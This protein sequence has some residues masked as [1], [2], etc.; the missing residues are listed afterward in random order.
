MWGWPRGRASSFLWSSS[1]AS[2]TR[3]ARWLA[4]WGNGGDG[5][6]GQRCC[7][8]TSAAGLWVAARLAPTT[9][10]GAAADVAWVL[11]LLAAT[12][13][14]RSWPG[15]PAAAPQRQH[16][17]DLQQQVTA[18]HKERQELLRRVN[19]LKV[20]ACLAA[21]CGGVKRWRVAMEGGAG[22]TVRLRLRH[23]SMRLFACSS[24]AAPAR[25]APPHRRSPTARRAPR[26]RRAWPTRWPRP[27]TRRRRRRTLRR[28]RPPPASSSDQTDGCRPQRSRAC[29]AASDR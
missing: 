9:A 13:T 11:A 8:S 21:C 4:G 6:R 12:R 17:A 7:Q 18:L 24:P 28:A 27:Q 15:R 26:W 3:C 23:V 2:P 20:G 22:V 16:A 25:P 19:T 29:A 5:S 1:G 14:H 10:A